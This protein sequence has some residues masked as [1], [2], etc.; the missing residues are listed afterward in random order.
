MITL[1]VVPFS[2]LWLEGGMDS[3]ALAAFTLYN[4]VK[5]WEYVL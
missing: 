1:K 2:D 3:K 5:Q 4:K